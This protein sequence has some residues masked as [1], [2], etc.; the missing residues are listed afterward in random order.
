M[1]VEY[2]TTFDDYIAF[3]RHTRRQSWIVFFVRLAF[4]LFV[5]FWLVLCPIGLLIQD[6]KSNWPF[7]AFS[8][9]MAPAA[10]AL[11]WILSRLTSGPLLRI[12]AR[13]KIQ[14]YLGKTRLVLNDEWLTGTTEAEKSA[15]MWRQIYRMDDAGDYFFIYVSRRAGVIVPKHAFE[16]AE[17]DD[18]LK[19]YAKRCF[20]RQR[21]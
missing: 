1:E 20:E 18:R 6:A 11:H 8:L 5:L 9:A 13:K 12:F 17:Q 2:H 4:S 21:R 16:S 14:G 3:F 15:Y 19:A 10:L 7:A